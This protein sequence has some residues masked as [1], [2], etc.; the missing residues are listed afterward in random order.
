M[1]VN[2]YDELDSLKQQLAAANLATAALEL[3]VAALEAPPVPAPP[4]HRQP[5]SERNR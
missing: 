4:P 5:R 1:A 3:R 2:I